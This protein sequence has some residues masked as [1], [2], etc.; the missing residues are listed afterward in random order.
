MPYGSVGGMERL[1][2]TFYNYYKTQGY[3]VKALKFIKLPSDIIHFGNDEFY[4]SKKD[5]SEMSKTERIIFYLKAPG[6]IKKIIRKE[7]ISHSISFGDMANFF[8]SLSKSGEYKI[9]SIHAVKSIEFQGKSFLNK[10]YKWSYRTTYKN[11]DKLVCISSAIKDDLLSNCNYKFPENIQVIYNPHDLYEINTKSNEEIECEKEN[12]LF[13]KK[14]IIFI[15]RMSVQKSPWHLITA[16]SLIYEKNPDLNLVFIGD[17][18]KRVQEHIEK[19]IDTFKIKDRVYF[20]GRKSNPYKYLKRA[21]VL[22][23]SSHYEGT[24]NV[25]AEA[26]CLSVPIVSSNCTKGITEMM[27][28]N[29]K[30]VNDTNVEC[31]AG[32]ITPNLYKGSLGIPDKNDITPEEKKLAEALAL[33]VS[34]DKYKKRLIANREELLDKFNLDVVAR[35]YLGQP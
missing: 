13:K 32:I 30:N 33:V 12:Q 34:S 4:L 7:K 9:G 31:E 23:L 16:F 18:D 26:I 27:S 14:C 3:N 24:P 5:F 2:F 6:R 1:A 25:I 22:A 20:L 11:L 28:I 17:G 29:N 15:G 35:K 21:A 8:I 19:L 10:L